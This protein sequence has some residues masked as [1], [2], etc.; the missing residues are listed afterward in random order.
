MYWAMTAVGPAPFA[1]VT[2]LMPAS[3]GISDVRQPSAARGGHAVDPDKV[4]P[5]YLRMLL[6]FEDRRFYSHNGVDPHGLLRAARDLVLN[7]RIVT[8]GSTLTMQVARLLDNQYRRTPAVKLRQ[9]VRAIQLESTLTKNQILRLYLGLAP[10]GGRVTGVRAASLKFFGKEPDQL[11]DGEAA[12]LVA[13]PQA[14]EARRPDRDAEAALRARNFVLKTVAAAG[15]ITTDEAERATREPL[16]AEAAP[17]PEIPLPKPAATHAAGLFA[18]LTLGLNMIVATPA[19]SAPMQPEH[20]PHGH[21]LGS[22]EQVALDTRRRLLA[23]L[24]DGTKQA[25]RDALWMFYAARQAPVWVAMTGWTPAARAVI[26]EIARADDWGLEASAFDVPALPAAGGMPLPVQQLSDAETGLSLAVLK[27]ARYARGGRIEDPAT[28]LSSYL[29]RRPQLRNPLLVM[30][31]IA[32]AEAPDDYLRKLHPQHEQFA[33]LR[34]A[35]LAHRDGVVAESVAIP[36]GSKIKPGATHEHIALIRERLGIATTGE[37]GDHYDDELVDAVKRF[38]AKHDIAPANGVI[39][40]KTRRALNDRKAVSLSTVLANMEQWRW[41][42]EDLGDVHVWVNVPEFRVRVVN[43]G[44]TVL[45]E[46]VITGATSTQTPIFS[47]D[48]ETIYFHPRWNIPPSI[49]MKDVYPSLARGGGYFYRQGLKVARNG[50]EV[51]PRSVNWYKADIRNYDIY[52]PSG[53]GNALGLM[54]FTFPNKHAVYMHDTQSK[55]L[56]DASQRTFSHGCVRVKNPLALAQLLLGI[57]KGWTP[58]E[59]AELLNGDP[60][61][62]GV[63]LDKHIPVHLAYF[64]AHVGS[65]GEVTTEPDIYGHEKRISQALQGKWKDIDKGSDHLAQVQLAERLEDAQQVRK[66]RGRRVVRSG[67][68]EVGYAPRFSGSTANDV[69]R[70][71]FG[72]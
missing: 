30:I 5:R 18:G 38:Q 23:P 17:M 3:A 1:R 50:K 41:M 47:K 21:Y 29:D 14:P 35:Y 59:V 63:H 10:F 68:G 56:F 44:A 11:S 12:L 62:L 72:F 2:H 26:D 40:A 70:R 39:N 67:G 65:D 16:I 43:E 24:P 20:Q 71:S 52:Q 9:I 69:F 51:S 34:D 37:G 54:K 36:T 53:P 42:P 27:Y 22:V 33:R 60:E 49:K 6:A 45:D 13:L 4:D 58:D 61:E 19:V 31:G 46:R 32:A 7:G 15:V 25:D 66:G 28:Q 48:L 57:D 64:T 8:G 55:G